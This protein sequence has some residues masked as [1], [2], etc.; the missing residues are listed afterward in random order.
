MLNIECP[1]IPLESLPPEW[2][3]KPEITRELGNKWLWER[4]KILLKCRAAIVPEPTQLLLRN[5]QVFPTC[6]NCDKGIPPE[7][8]RRA[9]RGGHDPPYCSEAC[10]RAFNRRRREEEQKRLLPMLNEDEE[11][12]D[13]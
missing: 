11:A 8:R 12:R 10:R 4:A 9:A 5:N 1:S 6:L 3:R 13:C 2:T 7:R